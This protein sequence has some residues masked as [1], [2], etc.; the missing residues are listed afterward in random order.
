MKLHKLARYVAAIM[1]V[2][3]TLAVMGA[4]H[5]TS[6]KSKVTQVTHI[7]T[8]DQCPYGGDPAYTV[9]H[10]IAYIHCDSHGKE[11]YVYPAMHMADIHKP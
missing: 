7:M 6:H 4:S 2:P 11:L 9:S 5:N 1:I 3:V 10:N 8:L